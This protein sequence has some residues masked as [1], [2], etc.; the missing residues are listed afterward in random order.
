M[1]QIISQLM[2]Q[3]DNKWK[4]FEIISIG[5]TLEDVEKLLGDVIEDE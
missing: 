3:N 5:N 2:I 4:L 1:I